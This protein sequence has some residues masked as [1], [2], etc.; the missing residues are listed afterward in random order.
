MLG[1]VGPVARLVRL[2][3]WIAPLLLLATMPS[4]VLGQSLLAQSSPDNEV[5]DSGLIYHSSGSEVR[6]VFFATDEHQHAVREL[7]EDDFAVVDGDMVI[8]QFRSFERSTPAKLDAVVLIDASGSVSSRFQQQAAD[9]FQMLSNWPW[10]P[11]DE[12][13]VLSFSGSD[14]HFICVEDCVNSL[15]SDQIASVPHG[16]STPLFD[17]LETAAN[18]LQQHHEP[19]VSRV[20]ILFS[21]GQDTISKATLQEAS[22]RVVASAAQLYAVD[23]GNRDP[24]SGVAVLQQLANDSGGRYVRIAKNSS[25]NL[26][27][28]VNSVVEDMNSARIVT[29]ALP[30]SGSGNHMVRILPT[31]NLAWEFHCRHCFY[32][33]SDNTN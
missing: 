20:I 16:G 27:D 14:V 11:G 12:L 28:V 33:H 22:E 23:S 1:I 7:R 21:D 9:I 32:N 17:A 24:G 18:V 2:T 19:D 8:R 30:E 25:L 31:R 4:S 10:K 6:L 13:S 5:N 15:T 26:N 3:R 29:Y